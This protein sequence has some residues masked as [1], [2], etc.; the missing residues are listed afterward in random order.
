MNQAQIAK[1][2]AEAPVSIK[3][4]GSLDGTQVEAYEAAVA[5][6]SRPAPWKLAIVRV[7]QSL[8]HGL[9]AL[10]PFGIAAG[11]VLALAEHPERL[12]DTL[13]GRPRA[14]SAGGG[15]HE[16]SYYMKKSVLRDGGAGPTVSRLGPDGRRVLGRV[17]ANMAHIVVAPIRQFPDIQDGLDRYP[18][19]R[20]PEDF[21]D[22]ILLVEG[23]HVVVDDALSR[24]FANAKVISITTQSPVSQ[25]AYGE[26]IY[27]HNDGESEGASEYESASRSAM[28]TVSR[29]L[30]EAGIE[31]TVLRGG[32][33]RIGSAVVRPP[34]EI[35]GTDDRRRWIDQTAMQ[36]VPDR[37]LEELRRNLPDE[38]LTESPVPGERGYALPL[39]TEPF[40]QVCATHASLS[41][42]WIT[43]N[44]LRAGPHWDRLRERLRERLLNADK[45]NDA[46]LDEVLREFPPDLA[47]ELAQMAREASARIRLD[48]TLAHE[49]PVVIVLPQGEIRF[50]PIR[51]V[52][53][54]EV[55][56]THT[57]TRGTT[58]G[59]LRLLTPTDPLPLAVASPDN[60]RQMG[61][62]W[63][64]A[65]CAYAEL[66]CVD[67]SSIVSRSRRPRHSQAT[68][69]R[70]KTPRNSGV[71]IGGRPLRLRPRIQY[72]EA[73]IASRET[74][75]FL[76]SYVAGH[77]R[78]LQPG[79]T[80]SRDAERHA[81]AI[82]ITLKDDETWVRP[83]TRGE[84]P[85]EDLRF[86]WH[87]D[88]SLR[89]SLQSL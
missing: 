1:F 51:D 74:E 50:E 7:P 25:A 70:T 2:F 5:H 69:S 47:P 77:R 36:L 21:F 76:A 60:T 4:N 14:P 63:A 86:T 3:G 53:A 6:F 52:V 44:F 34:P 11:R 41:P 29:F 39:R 68:G 28:F 37:L 62:V 38:F 15:T 56:F 72:S 22:M 42:G 66:T 32:Q 26:V 64:V 61:V 20:Y 12:A 31:T 75:T 65:L 10:L 81:R 27:H 48:R 79:Q 45:S 89:A 80:H 73:L 83:H 30:R 46:D 16:D 9:I 17:P 67:I 59:A 55:P 23:R 87:A 33:M 71:E 18:E 35:E 54:L 40:P 8:V 57:G 82:A 19:D 58:R 85:L 13:D 43:G 49:H 84:P 24:R 88:D 78:R